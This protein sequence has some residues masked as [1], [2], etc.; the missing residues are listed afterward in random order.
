MD[1]VEFLKTKQ[2]IC[3]A[4]EY[5]REC[6]FN[7]GEFYCTLNVDPEKAVEAVERWGKEHPLKTN[8]DKI[9]E[10]FPEMI[11]MTNMGEG[12]AVQC[13]IFPTGYLMQEYK[14]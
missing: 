1:A 10:M 9:K 13:V 4:N 14:E 3:D 6:E 7:T 12:E 11:A 2:R 5:C 8:L